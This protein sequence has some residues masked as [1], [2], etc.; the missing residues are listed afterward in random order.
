[1]LLYTSGTLFH[2][3]NYTERLLRLTKSYNQSDS[4]MTNETF[5][6]RFISST[7]PNNSKIN[8]STA[9]PEPWT[10][11]SLVLT[12]TRPVLL[13]VQDPGLLQ[14]SDARVYQLQP[15]CKLILD[16]FLGVWGDRTQSADL[17]W[18]FSSFGGV[19]AESRRNLLRRFEWN[20]HGIWMAC[21]RPE[22]HL[23]PPSHDQKLPDWMDDNHGYFSWATK[24]N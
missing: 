16:V 20:L 2:F 13:M 19:L 10:C 1:M 8:K 12:F 4:S 6:S 11:E 23:H 17:V 14:R 5:A 7:Y 18:W 24:A 22:R 9:T 3:T 21:T 15:R